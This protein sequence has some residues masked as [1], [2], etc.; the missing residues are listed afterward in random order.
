MA[1]QQMTIKKLKELIADLPED[2][3]LY[4]RTM[5][6][7]IGSANS[8]GYVEYK[9]QLDFVNGLVSLTDPE[10]EDPLILGHQ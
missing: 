10:I 9:G 5:A 2:W 7:A 1:E 4:T 8:D 6:I 3:F